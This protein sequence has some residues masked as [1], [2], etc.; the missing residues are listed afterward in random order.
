MATLELIA[1]QLSDGRAQIGA[2][3]LKTPTAAP[4]DG[5][6][7]LDYHLK[8]AEPTGLEPATS[9]VTERKSNPK[10]FAKV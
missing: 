1:G 6:K 10:K 5:C 7:C 9:D 3:E 8:V 4:Q 2:Q